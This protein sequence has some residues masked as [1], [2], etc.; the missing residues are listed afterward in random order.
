MAESEVPTFEYNAQQRLWRATT[1]ERGTE[2]VR[3]ASVA[4]PGS[5]SQYDQA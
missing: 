2:N 1:P 5:H 4:A 3:V